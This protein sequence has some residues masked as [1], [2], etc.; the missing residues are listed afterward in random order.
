M[1]EFNIRLLQPRRRR[2]PQHTSVL[3]VRRAA[4]EQPPIQKSVARSIRRAAA[5]C[6]PPC[7]LVLAANSQSRN[8]GS[9]E[10]RNRTHSYRMHSPIP[11]LF[12]PAFVHTH[13]ASL[14]KPKNSAV[15]TSPHRIEREGTHMLLRP[16]PA[17]LL[18]SCRRPRVHLTAAT[19]TCG[20]ARSAPKAQ[21]YDRVRHLPAAP[22]P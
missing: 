20:G 4:H 17:A 8:T 19:T 12:F 9:I 1:R 22:S 2:G 13:D 16:S 21:T 18:T 14:N 7:P 5:C 3:H 6:S 15:H 11:V 10:R